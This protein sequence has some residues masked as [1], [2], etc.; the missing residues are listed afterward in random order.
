MTTTENTGAAHNCGRLASC[1]GHPRWNVTK[2]RRDGQRFPWHAWAPG[3][4]SSRDDAFR[5][6][7]EAV[8]YATAQAKA[9]HHHH[10]R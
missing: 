5:T 6:H 9:D 10:H 3:N 1:L 8:A 4:G 7:E 2:T